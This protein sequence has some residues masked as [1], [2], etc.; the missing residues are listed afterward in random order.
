MPLGAE[1]TALA[2]RAR[3]TLVQAGSSA[4]PP[5]LTEPPAPTSPQAAAAL[6]LT[7]REIDVLRLVAG[8]RTNQQIAETLYIS[9]KTAGHHVSSILSKL[10]VASRVEAAGIAH[11]LGLDRDTDPK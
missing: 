10:G 7:A 8:G 9:P 1:I 4:E 3:L 11:R 2:R 6:R 5:S